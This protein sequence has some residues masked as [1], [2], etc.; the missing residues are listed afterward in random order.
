MESLPNLGDIRKYI[1]LLKSIS[2]P[3]RKQTN[4]QD[5][6]WQEPARAELEE[7]LSRIPKQS[8][9]GAKFTITG[10]AETDSNVKGRLTG[11][12][13]EPLSDDGRLEADSQK[14]TSPVVICSDLPRT[15]EHALRKYFSTD[16]VTIAELDKQLG[17]VRV[18]LETKE[19]SLP[20]YTGL[21][22][23]ALEKGII[24]TPLLRAQYFGPLELYIEKRA[25]DDKK[26]PTKRAELNKKIED[27]LRQKLGPGADAAIAELG[28]KVVLRQDIAA[29]LTGAEN[30]VS[31]FNRSA[32]NVFETLEKL[33]FKNVD[34][35][36]HSGFFDIAAAYYRHKE[37]PR[38]LHIVRLPT[39]K[40][41]GQKLVLTLDEDYLWLNDPQAIL[42]IRN[43]T[44]EQINDFAERSHDDQVKQGQGIIAPEFYALN[45][46][47]GNEKK[48]EVT[49]DQILAS[50]KPVLVLGNCGLGKTT[51]AMYLATQLKGDYVPILLRLRT[52]AD[53]IVQVMPGKRAVEL[54]KQLLQGLYGMSEQNQKAYLS[55]GKKF[56][57]IWDGLDEFNPSFTP[58]LEQILKDMSA[59][60]HK[61]IMTSRP[62]G[63]Q[64]NETLNAGYR[65]VNIDEQAIV[66]N[67]EQYLQSRIANP[68]QLKKFQAFLSKQKSELTQNWLM[69]SI[70]TQLYT[71]EPYELD[72]TSE[73]TPQKVIKKG[74]EMFVWQHGMERNPALYPG[75]DDPTQIIA[76][77][78]KYLYD[79]KNGVIPPTALLVTYMTITDQPVVSWDEA[80]R[81]VEQDVWSPATEVRYRMGQRP[82]R[83]ITPAEASRGI[84]ASNIHEKCPL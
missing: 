58:Q 30:Y 68:E 53:N 76:A 11:W 15:I 74:I 10:H 49:L 33:G 13:A 39:P 22:T 51:F 64:R 66:R 71:R 20:T 60:G 35:V 28:E 47:A 73:M 84:T 80:R 4:I 27:E 18:D 23:L 38:E 41:R 61:V 56:V 36:G 19:V 21:V 2:P 63:F 44:K 37:N 16:T 31:F 77:K 43:A 40:E 24:P 12:L 54:Q 52:A 83:F 45:E 59:Q 7:L 75:A 72:L 55:E 78:N 34:I 26:D 82:D 29:V 50:D 5:T 48:T 81:I 69:M 46:V 67:V 8:G 65:T 6:S 3:I 79:P 62:G 25:Q 42:D 57:L 9:D 17:R 70:L 14:N 32:R 1:E